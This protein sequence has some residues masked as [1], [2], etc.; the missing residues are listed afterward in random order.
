MNRERE[1]PQNAACNSS[2]SLQPHLALLLNGF[3]LGGES[4]DG[5]A[6]G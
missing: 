5:F 6:I 4:S 3:F 2:I 1:V